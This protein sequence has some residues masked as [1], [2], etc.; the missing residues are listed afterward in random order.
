MSPILPVEPRPERM[1]SKPGR[2]ILPGLHLIQSTTTRQDCHA[3]IARSAELLEDLFGFTILLAAEVLNWAGTPR[4]VWKSAPGALADREVIDW[5]GRVRPGRTLA[6]GAGATGL[7]AGESESGAPLV[8]LLA[9]GA[10][11]PP[12]LEIAMRDIAEFSARHLLH[13]NREEEMRRRQPG[14]GS[15][16]AALLRALAELSWEA[17]PDGVLRV[18]E[19]FHD[20][21]DLARRLEGSKLE[22]IAPSL[23]P[24][25]EA[26]KGRMHRSC[27]IALPGES[28]HL[29]LAACV[30]PSD[31]GGPAL[32]GTVAVLD[33]AFEASP[34]LEARLL[35]SVVM[36]RQREEQ[37]RRETEVMMLGLRA[38][39]SDVPFRE[40]LAQLVRQ[41]TGAIGGDEARLVLTRPGDKPRLIVPESAPLDPRAFAVLDGPV[42]FSPIRLLTEEGID[43]RRLR[44]ALGLPHGDVLA[45]DLPSTGEHYHLICR[46]RRGLSQNDYSLVERMSLL[47]RQAML[48]QDDQKQMIHAAKLSALGQMSTGIA[49]ELRQPLNAMSIAAQNID[50]MVEMDNI[51]PIMLREKTGRILAQVERASKIMDRMRRFGRKTAGDHKPINL[52]TM[53]RSARS[54]MDAVITGAGISF[55]IAVPDAVTV[56]AD[57]LEIEQVLV[58][59]IQNAID[60]LTD[61]RGGHIRFWSSEDP[62]QAGMVR[63]HVED[64]GPGFPPEVQKHALDAFFTTKPEGKGT[65]LGLSIAHSILREHGGRIL[66]GKGATGGGLVT[67]VLRRP[68]AVLIPLLPRG[69][70]EAAV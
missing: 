14:A 26:S 62:E 36:A 34:M 54:M 49:H 35:E 4:I 40:K 39:L 27:R 23:I 60:A 15:K 43:L 56:M 66:I 68:D 38:L 46:T 55:E 31:D 61:R 5:L 3:A 25:A 17:G 44:T 45:I 11:L 65:G 37:F 18:T 19:V 24:I 16:E 41:L 70:P 1:A 63:L 20:R 28:A 22:D 47:L 50:L 69:A 32:R 12:D 8:L 64:N 52:A 42:G 29:L 21:R 57:E 9:D 13:L 7:A 59:L 2:G 53:A 10:L 6:F 51:S 67:L 48:I 33:D 58:N 30:D